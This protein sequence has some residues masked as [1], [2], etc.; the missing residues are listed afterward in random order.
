[1]LGDID[2]IS[3]PI[4]FHTGTQLLGCTALSCLIRGVRLSRAKMT[5]LAN[6]SLDYRASVRLAKADTCII[7]LRAILD[8][9]EFG[10]LSLHWIVL[11]V[12]LKHAIFSS[13]T[14]IISLV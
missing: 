10:T 2:K 6:I 12:L 5:T 8:S 9:D 3:F 4:F 7:L 11:L 1:M 13:R 14:D